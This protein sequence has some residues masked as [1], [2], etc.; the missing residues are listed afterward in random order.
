MRFLLIICII[1][2]PFITLADEPTAKVVE[3]ETLQPT[4]FTHSERLIGTIQAK[5][6]S[7]LKA[8]AQGTIEWIAEPGKEVKAGEELVKLQN[9]EVSKS[10]ALAKNSEE[11]AK[12]KYQR[13]LKLSEAQLVKR[14][15]LED[16]HSSWIEAQKN[17]QTAKK[18]YEKYVFSAPFD[19]I[20][21]ISKFHAGSQVAEGD[22]LITIYKPSELAIEFNI[23]EKFLN[24]IKVGQKLVLN[25]KELKLEAVQ[26]FI[27]QTTHMAP[28]LVK[29][30]CEECIV[31]TTVN[32]DLVI[33]EKPD[34][35]T[36]PKYAIISKDKKEFVYLAKENKAMMIDIQTGAAEK[37]RVEVIYGLEAGDQLIITSLQRLMDGQPIQILGS[38]GK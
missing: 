32:I 31:G 28:A 8:K 25:G 11:L 24:Q 2:L 13:T 10:Y 35:I 37:D 27:D 21:S 14:S 12:Q 18:E 22:E 29:Y 5:Y 20:I 26:K 16:D 33:S 38:L 7:V 1:I 17:V 6:L 36:I 34:A 15:T 23:P 19:G 9:S 4:K 3:V 30:P